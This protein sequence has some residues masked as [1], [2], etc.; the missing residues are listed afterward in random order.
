MKIAFHGAART[1]TGSQHLLTIDGRHVLLDC[2]LYQGRRTETYTRNRT[3]PFE[4][5]RLDAVVLSHA[6]IDHS[7]NLP[8]LA[9]NAFGGPIHCTHAT[10]DLCSGMLQDSAAIQESDAAFVSRRNAERGAAPVEPLYTLA[11]AQAA[12]RLFESHAYGRAFPVVPGV[13]ATYYDAGHILGSAVTVLDIAEGSRQL[14]LCFSGDLGR[15]NLPILRDPQVVPDIDVLIIESTYGDKVHAPIDQAE[16]GL[17][18]AVR[19]I[20][21]T[22]G[23]MIIPAFA[24][25][26]TQEI[27]YSLH[28]LMDRGAIPRI[29]IFVDSPLAV[30]VTEVFQHHPECYDQ[31]TAQFIARDRHGTAFGFDQLT[32]VHSVEESKAL[33]ARPGPFVIIS[34]SGMAENG[35]VLHHLRNNVGDARTIVLLVSWSAPDTLARKLADGWPVV[36]IF[37]E[38]H[39][40]RARVRSIHGYSAH[41][42]RNGL[43]DYVRA[44]RP[45][46]KQVF[47]VHGEPGPAEALAGGIRD[48]GV[49]QVTVPDLHQEVEV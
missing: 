23:K 39:K 11:D 19:D 2:G 25:G 40:V 30:N 3:F 28:Q 18:Q 31:E 1:V 8:N 20:V 21:A 13:Q 6:H 36:R 16:A 34:A 5:R 32:Y 9:A 47:I 14:R 17:E 29:P 26:R 33:N 4:A 46:V 48:L 45:Q 44:L 7:G 37:G 35:R 38:E 27:V 49:K 22:G 43:L 15:A 41:A 24:V 12:L 42:D 10:R